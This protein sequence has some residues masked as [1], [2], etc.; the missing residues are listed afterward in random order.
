M[1]LLPYFEYY[2]TDKNEKI[3][4]V[5]M[6]EKVKSNVPCMA[7]NFEVISATKFFNFPS[8]SNDMFLNFNT[9]AKTLA[10]ICRWEKK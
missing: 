6:Y 5:S 1:Q 2:T 10:E 4:L 3:S 9:I 8:N 7:S